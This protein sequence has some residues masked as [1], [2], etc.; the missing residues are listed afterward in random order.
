MSDPPEHVLRN[1][2]F[3]DEKAQEFIK[4]GEEAWERDAPAWG[5]WQ[6]P[7][8]EVQMLPDSVA[9]KDIIELGCGTAYV[10]AWLARKGARVVGI[11][12]SRAQLATA[13]RLQQA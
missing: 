8:S 9:D 5:V 2:A 6:I 11:D 10:S 1:R 7:E 12:N 13:R 3:W 4:A